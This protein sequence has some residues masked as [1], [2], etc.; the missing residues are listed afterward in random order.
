MHN[1]WLRTDN[2]VQLNE[3]KVFTT[4][5]LLT[6]SEATARVYR[7][8]DARAW[9]SVIKKRLHRGVLLILFDYAIDRELIG[10]WLRNEHVV[11]AP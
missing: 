4:V 1:Y 7:S 2:V 5:S 11:T 6:G 9:T 8:Y 3:C 10:C